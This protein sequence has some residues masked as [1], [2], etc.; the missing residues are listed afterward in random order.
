MLDFNELEPYIIDVKQSK[1][2]N[3]ATDAWL[4]NNM[5]THM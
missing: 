3:R 4:Q 2:N 5:D 1:L